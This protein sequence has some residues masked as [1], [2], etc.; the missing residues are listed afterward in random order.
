MAGFSVIC[1][2]GAVKVTKFM[3]VYIKIFSI[4]EV[5]TLLGLFVG[6]VDCFFFVSLR[7]FVMFESE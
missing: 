7:L 2:T 3:F 4:I 5:N 1:C 6:A